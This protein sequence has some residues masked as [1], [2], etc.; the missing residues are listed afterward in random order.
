[1]GLRRREILALCGAGLAGLAGY[2]SGERDVKRTPTDGGDGTATSDSGNA[3]TATPPDTEVRVTF[4]APQPAVV[5]LDVD[6]LRMVSPTDHQYPYLDVSVTSGTPP[7][8]PDFGVRFGGVVYRPMLVGEN[9]TS[10]RG[11]NSSGERHYGRGGDEGGSGWVLFESPATGHASDA[12]LIWP[13]GEWVPDEEV[14]RQLAAP[15]PSLSLGEWSVPE[16]IPLDS[17]STFDRRVRNE[18]DHAGRFVGGINASGWA[19]H[20]PITLVSRRIPPYESK[21]WGGTGEEIEPVTEGLSN[22]VGDGEANMEY[23]LVCTDGNQSRAV[24]VGGV[25]VCRAIVPHDRRI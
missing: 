20:R 11:M 8:L 21:S 5:E 16:A 12:I 25:T 15:S 3:P 23:A 14:R 4:D 7:S 1:M 13:G 22:R 24:R 2:A 6:Y 10:Y 18:S 17:R 9:R 19:P